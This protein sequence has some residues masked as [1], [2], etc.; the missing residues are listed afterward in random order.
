MGKVIQDSYGKTEKEN[1]S[2]ENGRDLHRNS[3]GN[4]ECDGGNFEVCCQMTP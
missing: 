2:A 1:L 3:I 4:F